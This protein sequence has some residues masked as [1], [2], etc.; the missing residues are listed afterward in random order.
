MDASSINY[1][2]E[3]NSKSLRFQKKTRW[4]FIINIKNKSDIRQKFWEYFINNPKFSRFF[5]NVWNIKILKSFNFNWVWQ[6]EIGLEIILK[7]FRAFPWKLFTNMT[8]ISDWWNS[9]YKTYPLIQYRTWW[10]I[11]KE[12]SNLHTLHTWLLYYGDDMKDA[13]VREPYVG[14]T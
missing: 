3:G 2:K 1:Q 10:V 7:N 11:F 5:E 14:E 6:N 12:S 4:K 8:A 9:W 13:S